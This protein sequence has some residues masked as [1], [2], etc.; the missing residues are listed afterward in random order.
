MLSGEV[1]IQPCGLQ[2]D[3]NGSRTLARSWPPHAGWDRRILVLVPQT[4]TSRKF[5]FYLSLDVIY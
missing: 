3:A 4:T 1:E 2:G 5:Y